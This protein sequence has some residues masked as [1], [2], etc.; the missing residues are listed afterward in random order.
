M[1]EKQCDSMFCDTGLPATKEIPGWNPL[2]PFDGSMRS[3]CIECYEAHVRVKDRMDCIV[4]E[5]REEK[6]KWMGVN[7]H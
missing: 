2:A 5:A 4:K 7:G 1:N 6:A 3:V